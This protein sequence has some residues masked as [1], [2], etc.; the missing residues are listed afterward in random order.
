[1]GT[2][3]SSQ[4]RFLGT[5]AAL[6]LLACGSSKA[7]KQGG[8]EGQP[9]AAAQP[10]EIAP[11]KASDAPKQA[12]SETER[13]PKTSAELCRETLACAGACFDAALLPAR[14]LPECEDPKSEGCKEAI[15]AEAPPPLQA[16]VAGLRCALPCGREHRSRDDL[17][18][19]LPEQWLAMPEKERAVF[20]GIVE[21]RNCRPGRSCDSVCDGGYPPPPMVLKRGAAAAKRA[22][23][24]SETPKKAK[25]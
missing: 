23:A 13:T 18:G 24:Q 12:E 21:A 17:K 22:E 10:S 6:G 8:A 16:T 2:T 14:S 20:T 5:I 7:P 25:D 1:M 11:L 9:S 15:E 3:Q 4:A 19:V